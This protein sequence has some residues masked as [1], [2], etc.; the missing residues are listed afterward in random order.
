[1]ALRNIESSL[2]ACAIRSGGSTKRLE[3][4]E[5]R[6]YVTALKSTVTIHGVPH[7]S[8]ARICYETQYRGAAVMAKGG[9]KRSEWY[10]W[11]SYV[12]TMA[13][14]SYD[15][16][17][18]VRNALLGLRFKHA[19]NAGW[20]S[21]NFDNV[22]FILGAMLG[23]LSV[24]PELGTADFRDRARYR[25]KGV[26]QMRD[27]FTINE[28]GGIYLH[29]HF[30][31]VDGVNA[32]W[33]FVTA[34][35]IGGADVLL[36][37]VDCDGNGAPI[38]RELSGGALTQGITSCLSLLGTLY[39]LAGAGDAFAVCLVKGLHSVC[40]V[41][42]HSDEGGWM[43]DV[44]RHGGFGPSFGGVPQG[45]SFSAGIPVICSHSLATTSAY[46]DSMLYVS[47]AL[48]AHC[49]PCDV[50]GPYVF[51]TVIKALA[52]AEETG[53][54]G[55]DELAK[56]LLARLSSP[57]SHFAPKYA[58]GLARVF[59]LI[60]SDVG[61]YGAAILEN[62]LANFSESAGSRSC[63]H[64]HLEMMAPFFWIEPTGLI[65]HNYLGTL[66]EEHGMGS[67]CGN[68]EK[69]SVGFLNRPQALGASDMNRSA[70]AIEMRSLRTWGG[71]VYLANHKDDGVANLWLR[72]FDCEG[73]VLTK[74]KAGD[75]YKAKRSNMR[76]DPGQLA[77]VRGQSQIPHPAECLNV[78]GTMGMSILHRVVR[79]IWVDDVRHIPPADEVHLA[80][81]VYSIGPLMVTS[82]GRPSWEPRLVERERTRG[83]ETLRL[84]RAQAS[85]F[86]LGSGYE[87]T[88][89]ERPPS[90]IGPATVHVKPRSVNATEPELERRTAPVTSRGVHDPRNDAHVDSLG[91]PTPVAR[92]H[93]AVPAP[94]PQAPGGLDSG[95]FTDTASVGVL[96]IDD[97][98]PPAVA[99]K[100]DAA[101]AGAGQTPA[102]L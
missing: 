63:R 74:M 80:R 64:L 4:D 87:E 18:S 10:G 22:V 70:W 24:Y 77:W 101:A 33:A 53:S 2:L 93:G 90:E 68:T 85:S 79:D 55:K 92:Q 7:F 51:P 44:L 28:A 39:S 69:R 6:R 36:S 45:L 1:M 49:D 5:A 15:T 94:R 43:R 83:A 67:L 81:V 58:A 14:C 62:G 72:H 42:G 40:T 48:V 60:G 73:L 32:L 9:W 19:T 98:L 71:Y 20:A 38:C 27:M 86:G 65:P 52:D 102:A 12:D 57:F 29:Q 97:T 91:K 95:L 100:Q 11:V 59:G 50:N 21:F 37:N 99:N 35:N 34:A 16:P 78:D 82:N 23:A 47:A 46:V 26:N 54:V 89:S 66:A 61:E 76:V 3:G 31:P 17:E 75:V 25:V 88:V 84:C 30:C 13:A 8:S 96:P 56:R 41:V